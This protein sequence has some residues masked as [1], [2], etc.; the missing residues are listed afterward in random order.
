MMK[1]PYEHDESTGK[2]VVVWG[3]I[4]REIMTVIISTGTGTV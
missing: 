4:F 3:D 2:N 1:L